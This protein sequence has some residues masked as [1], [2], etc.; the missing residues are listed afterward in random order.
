MSN[1]SFQYGFRVLLMTLV[2]W[3][4]SASTVRTAKGS[5]SLNTSRF[6][7]PSAATTGF[8]CD[9]NGANMNFQHQEKDIGAD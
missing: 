2:V 9:L 6:D 1:D 3:V 7:R 4:C 5:G 8:R